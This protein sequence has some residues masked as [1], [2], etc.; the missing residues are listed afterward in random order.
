[1]GKLNRNIGAVLL[2]TIVVIVIGAGVIFRHPIKNQL[3]SWKL[4]PEPEKLTELYF[5]NSSTLPSTYIPGVPQLISFTVHNLEYQNWTYHYSVTAISSSNTITSI[6][7]GTFKLSQNQ[8]KSV[9]VDVAIPDLGSKVEVD[10]TLSA[11]NQSI[12][13]LVNRSGS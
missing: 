13:Y 6:S 2:V 9:P 7:S 3:N 5:N 11:P 12:D 10:V 4:L 8:Y 1:L